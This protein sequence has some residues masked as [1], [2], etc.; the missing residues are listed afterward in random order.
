MG[1]C[2][3]ISVN[4]GL[5]PRSVLQFRQTDFELDGRD[6]LH[7]AGPVTL[8]FGMPRRT[9][10]NIEAGFVGVDRHLQALRPRPD[11]YISARANDLFQVGREFVGQAIGHKNEESKLAD[12]IRTMTGPVRFLE[13]NSQLKAVSGIGGEVELIVHLMADSDRRPARQLRVNGA[14]IVSSEQPFAILIQRQRHAAKAPTAW[15]S[16]DALKAYGLKFLYCFARSVHSSLLGY[17]N[18][19]AG[20]RFQQV[21]AA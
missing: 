8:V 18:A 20:T 5:R 14:G 3:K 13:W 12:A 1:E 9:Q 17:E 21:R 6:N 19:M 4:G 2:S 15:A 7:H 16:L 11:E 10:V